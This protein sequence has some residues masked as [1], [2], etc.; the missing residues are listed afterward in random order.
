MSV[1]ASLSNLSEGYTT[2]V[3]SPDSSK[4]KNIEVINKS[5]TSQSANKVMLKHILIHDDI[6]QHTKLGEFVMVEVLKIAEIR[7]YDQ[8]FGHKKKGPFVESINTQLHADDGPLCNIKITSN[9]TFQKKIN[10]GLAV[11]DKILEIGHNDKEG[12]AGEDWPE[13]LK[14]LLLM[15]RNMRQSS[16]N[17][18]VSKDRAAVN[19]N[20]QLSH[21]SNTNFTN[22]IGPAR[23]SN[24]SKNAREG[25]DVVIRG[26]NS[27]DASNT[28]IVSY[29]ENP[30]FKKRPIPNVGLLLQKA[31]DGKADYKSV[32]EQMRLSSEV[33]E[34]R[35]EEHHRQKRNCM[36]TQLAHMKKQMTKKL[37]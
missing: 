25:H 8:C 3:V 7:G 32:A 12:D 2:N 17:D 29:K 4:N 37:Q 5:S 34:L 11:L 6:S 36:H 1:T 23:H 14:V 26:N 18:G 31:R 20:I 24:R 13:H 27:H 28:A 9:A 33:R 30:Q 16:K 35:I 10:Q 19:L 21:L 22:E 15:L